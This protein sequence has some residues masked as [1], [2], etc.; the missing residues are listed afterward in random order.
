MNITDTDEH[1]YEYTNYETEKESRFG[2]VSYQVAGGGMMNGNAYATVEL[3][4]ECYYYCEYG[5]H[6]YSKLI[7]NRIEWSDE[8]YDKQNPYDSRAFDIILEKNCI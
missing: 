6:P 4:D 2:V 3:K 7:G 1:E 5:Q 8:I